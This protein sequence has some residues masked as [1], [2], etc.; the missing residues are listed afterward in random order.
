MV[1][2]WTDDR[3]DEAE[4]RR[5]GC[6]ESCCEVIVTEL[7][8]KERVGVMLGWCTADGLVDFQILQ[9]LC[10]NCY[11]NK[12]KKSKTTKRNNTLIY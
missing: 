12:Y 3:Q 8:G 4:E 10:E 11:W 9:F 7:G 2:V 6:Q 1:D 5:G